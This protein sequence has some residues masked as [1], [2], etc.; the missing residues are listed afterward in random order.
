VPSGPDAIR[1]ELAYLVNVLV[2]ASQRRGNLLRAVDALE[3]AVAVAEFALEG[4]F[5]R[6]RLDSPASALRATP[7]DLW[8]RAGWRLL[9]TGE[10]DEI[11]LGALRAL[12]S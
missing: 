12:L 4:E 8:L 6:S 9:C 1:E 7:A 3:A 10:G 2:A 5:G 11:P